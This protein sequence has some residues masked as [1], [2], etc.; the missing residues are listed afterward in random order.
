MRLQDF[1]RILDLF[2]QV[3]STGM[4]AE[5]YAQGAWKGF[6]YNLHRDDSTREPNQEAAGSLW[7]RHCGSTFR[8]KRSKLR[9]PNIGGEPWVIEGCNTICTM[10]V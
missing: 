7:Q 8:H 9:V 3:G 5:S 2:G 6:Y 10:I 4:S 1:P